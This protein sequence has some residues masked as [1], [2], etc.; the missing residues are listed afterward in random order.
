MNIP[1]K[2]E[3]SAAGGEIKRKERGFGIV[4]YRLIQACDA[5]NYD[6]SFAGTYSSRTEE[7]KRLIIEKSWKG[8][9][10]NF[11]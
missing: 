7:G 6:G 3:L 1:T 11:W 2:A 10:S 5:L 8:H 9:Y 4:T